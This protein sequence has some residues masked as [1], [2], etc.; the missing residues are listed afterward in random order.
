WTLRDG[1]PVAIPVAA[2]LTDGQ[3]TEVVGGAIAPGTRLIVG[4]SEE[5]AT[6]ATPAS[7]GPGGG[8]PPPLMMIGGSR[9]R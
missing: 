6:P 7:S 5:G 8:H 3:W 1:V 4:V 2:G 9:G